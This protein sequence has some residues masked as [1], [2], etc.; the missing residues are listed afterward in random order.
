MSN[1]GMEEQNLCNKTQIHVFLSILEEIL[2]V[3]KF[4]ITYPFH[5]ALFAFSFV[6]VGTE[7]CLC[8]VQC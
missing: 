8:L 5:F 1:G 2:K 7:C 4:K 3:C 6:K